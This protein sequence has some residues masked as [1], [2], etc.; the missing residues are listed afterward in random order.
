MYVNRG[1]RQALGI[2]STHNKTVHGGWPEDAIDLPYLTPKPL[3]NYL[4]HSNHAR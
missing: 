1:V 4:S 2:D 3:L